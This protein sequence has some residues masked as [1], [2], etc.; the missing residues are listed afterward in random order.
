MSELTAAPVRVVVLPL[1]LSAARR[2]ASET[3]GL[4]VAEIVARHWDEPY[5]CAVQIHE[6]SIPAEWWPRVKVRGGA[7]VA[8]IGVPH[9]ANQGG[10]GLSAAFSIAAVISFAA[11]QPWLGAAFSAAAIGTAVGTNLLFPPP[12]PSLTQAPPPNTY[13]PSATTTNEARP[14]R[15]L[16]VLLGRRRIF[17]PLAAKPAVRFA[18]Q[19]TYTRVILFITC[20]RAAIEAIKI[21]ETPIENFTGISTE[22]RRGWHASELTFGG[23]TSGT[24]YPSTTTKGKTYTF[25]GDKTV[26][27]KDDGGA[28]TSRDYKSGQT[29]TFNGIAFDRTYHSAWDVDQQR[30]FQLYPTTTDTDAFDVSMAHATG[31]IRTAPAAGHAWTV[32]GMFKYGLYRTESSPPGKVSAKD[33]IFK[34]EWRKAGSA[35]PWKVS[36]NASF[37]ALKTGPFSWAHSWSDAA[38]DQLIE[39]R[40]TRFTTGGDNA[41]EDRFWWQVLS[42]ESGEAA[43]PMNGNCMLALE[44]QS[45][46]QLSGPLDQINMIATRIART[47]AGGTWST[48]APTRNP[49]SLALSVL[50]DPFA[51]WA[52]ADAEIDL[53]TYGEWFDDCVANGWTCDGYLEDAE[54]LDGKLL[55]DIGL[56]GFAAPTIEL[57]GR[58]SVVIDQPRASDGVLIT[59]ANSWDFRLETQRPRL[60]QAW[61]VGFLNP[62]KND[63][64]DE[65]LVYA[66]GYSDADRDAIIDIERFETRFITNGDIAW[67]RVRRH[68]NRLNY[69]RRRVTVKQDFEGLLLR[70]GLR[71]TV[72]YPVM[73][74][75]PMDS[76]RVK[77][78]T[79]NGGATHVVALTLD[80]AVT[81]VAGQ[82]YLLIGYGADG[83]AANYGLVT[84]AG[85]A[86]TVTL[87][88]QVPVATAPQVG[89][90]WAVVPAVK[91]WFDGQVESIVPAPDRSVEITLTEY[92][93]AIFADDTATPP[94]W[95][96]TLPDRTLPAVVVNEVRTG[97]DVMRI[98]AAG[99]FLP[100]I[101]IRIAD[102]LPAGVVA[103]TFVSARDSGTDGEWSQLTITEQGSGFFTVEGS[104]AEGYSYDLAIWRTAPGYVAG[105]TTAVNGVTVVGRTEPPE[106]IT[107]LALSVFGG[108]AYLSWQPLNETD[109]IAGGHIEFRIAAETSGATVNAARSIGASVPGN[110][111]MTALPALV[112]TYFAI[113]Y[114]ALNL[115]SP[116]ASVVLADATSVLA[117]STAGFVQDDNTFPGTKT[118]CEVSGTALRLTQ[119]GGVV[120]AAGEYLGNAGLDL[121]AVTTARW[122]VRLKTAIVSSTDMI[123]SRGEIDGWSDVDGVLT[124]S[125]ECDAWVEARF[126]NDN[127]AAS[128]T[129]GPWQRIDAGEVRA[130]AMDKPRLHLISLNPTR[131]I[132]ISEFRV[133]AETL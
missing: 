2:E 38:A 14:Y 15:A 98:T 100:R 63:D 102:N 5:P 81:M 89:F 64:V 118:N 132:S 52:K 34:V 91:S 103:Q 123:D 4:T 27:G 13:I 3:A 117:Y 28:T 94:A 111:T 53:T 112:G 62:D 32:S 74:E 24:S 30:P 33:V 42:A 70:R 97:L 66:A 16:P 87:A 43:V 129:W 82:S 55:P 41:Y 119:P 101:E 51:P 23:G 68:E 72:A 122:R 92:D 37:S 21:G 57:D 36:F 109:V 12:S 49:A 84:A 65:R 116:A 131:N 11:G 58:R 40:F 115:P 39:V 108:M 47:Y 77:A 79:L 124:E 6:A 99:V 113:V 125:T 31:V 83:A 54:D 85:T 22:F 1:V 20:G 90:V 130:R 127:P 75:A 76:G 46:G 88:A 18:G 71:C 59:P 45:S 25:T 44:I 126:T 96:S 10:Q 69:A 26:S 48:P 50:Q 78:R 29:I 128:P 60:P 73:S 114:D 7:T 104:I 133:Y 80:K 19:K 106:A 95:E 93:A 67:K 120:T 121:G 35:D 9:N 17:P 105:A 56:A 61:R 107:G 110:L 86:A 8:L